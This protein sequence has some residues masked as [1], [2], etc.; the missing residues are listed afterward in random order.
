MNDVRFYLMHLDDL[1]ASL[2]RAGS[3]CGGIVDPLSSIHGVF[4][5][6]RSNAL[7]PKSI[8]CWIWQ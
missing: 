3:P 1:W 5:E 2:F 6:Q 7:K 4:P 8:C